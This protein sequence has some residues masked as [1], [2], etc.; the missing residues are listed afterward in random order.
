MSTRLAKIQESSNIALPDNIY[1]ESGHGTLPST[2]PLC[3]GPLDFGARGQ[4]E[5]ICR[6]KCGFRYTSK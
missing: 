1:N 4:D 6:N 5:L 3:K 2:C